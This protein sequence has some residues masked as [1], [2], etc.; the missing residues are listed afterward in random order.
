MNIVEEMSLQTGDIL[1]FRGKT[2]MSYLLE[3]FGYS[4]YSH[5]GIVLKNPKF[6]NPDLEDG[7]YI[8][9]SS[10]NKTL[11]AENHLHKVGVQISD[12]TSVVEESVKGSVYVRRVSCVRDENFYTRL[13]AIHK[14]I[15]DKPY[16][17]N[18]YDWICAKYN[19]TCQL[20]V[21]SYFQSKSQFWCSALVS[22]IFCELGLCDKNINWSLMAPREFSSDENGHLTFTCEIGKETLLY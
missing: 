4:K 9:E 8:L 10:W 1:L 19:L 18:L 14:E 6:L 22:Y 12:L 16:D 7:L 21:Q 15:H 5:V 20:P 3:Y 11:D 17:L 13:S 2:Y